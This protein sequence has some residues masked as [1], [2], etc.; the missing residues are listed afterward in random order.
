MRLGQI[1]PGDL[2]IPAGSGEPRLG[3][4]LPLVVDEQKRRRS[5]SD[6]GCA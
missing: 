6:R 1:G 3:C 4:D 2:V 5:G